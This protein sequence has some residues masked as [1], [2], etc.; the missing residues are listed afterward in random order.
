MGLAEARAVAFEHWKSA[1]AGGDPREAGSRPCAPTFAE[2][3][4]SVIAIHAPSWRNPKSGLQWQASLRTYAYPT[5]GALPV[6]EITPG[7]VMAVRIS[8]LAC[9]ALQA[10]RA[11]SGGARDRSG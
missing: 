9:Q 2:A 11:G 7:H 3:A 8:G 1:K 5:L 10:E 4:E 6:S